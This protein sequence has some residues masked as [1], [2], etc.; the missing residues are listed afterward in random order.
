MPR[1][2]QYLVDIVKS[3]QIILDHVASVDWDSFYQ[4][5]LVQDA[6]IRRLEIIGEASRRISEEYKTKH[7]YLPWHEMIGM[8]NF[9]IHEYDAVDLPIIW[10]TIHENLP[11][12]L[13]QLSHLIDLSE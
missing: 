10:N 13:E 1:D 11:P 5:I 7:G 8:R 4:D 3:A 6:V 12:L 9:V 2:R